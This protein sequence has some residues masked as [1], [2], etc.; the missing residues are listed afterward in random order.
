VLELQ[1]GIRKNDKRLIT[2]MDLHNQTTSWLVHNLS[3]FGARTSDG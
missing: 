3:T 2:H 1:D